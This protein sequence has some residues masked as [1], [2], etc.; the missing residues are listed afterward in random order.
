M[1]SKTR[2]IEDPHGGGDPMGERVP[3][4]E[5]RPQNGLSVGVT[6]G[7]SL[8]WVSPTVKP[9]GGRAIGAPVDTKLLSLLFFSTSFYF[10]LEP[11]HGGTCSWV[12][13]CEYNFIVLFFCIL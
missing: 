7:V 5:G 8:R 13:T 1:S 11:S 3:D 9:W 10:Y 2:V 12:L 4:P 6:H